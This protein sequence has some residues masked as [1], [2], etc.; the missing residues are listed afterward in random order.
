MIDRHNAS[1]IIIVWTNSHCSRF[2][3]VK[4]HIIVNCLLIT[5]LQH[6][7][8][9]TQYYVI[10]I[11]EATIIFYRQ[12][13]PKPHYKNVHIDWIIGALGISWTYVG[14]NLSPMTRY[15]PTQD[16]NSYQTLSTVT[17]CPLF[18]AL[19]PGMIT[20]KLSRPVS[21]P[22]LSTGDGGS[23]VQ[24][25]PGSEQWPMSLGLVTTKRRA[26][27]SGLIDLVES[28]QLLLSLRHTPTK[29]REM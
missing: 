22:Y 29:E 9:S 2:S 19:T 25:D 26:H 14:Q 24:D 6:T 27:C 5:Y 15:A 7:S 21:R 20:I 16:S 3:T 28:W 17:V 4:F 18:A 23:V 8:R 13:Q 12:W 10:C 1:S 11:H